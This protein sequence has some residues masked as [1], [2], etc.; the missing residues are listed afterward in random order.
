MFSR[1]ESGGTIP[2]YLMV[3][4]QRPDI[5]IIDEKTK[6]VTIFELTVPAEPRLDIAHT[7]KT[8]SYSHFSSDIKSHKVKVIPFEVGSNTGHI[9][10]ENKRRL[11]TLHSYCMKD[12]KL[13]RFKENIS[14]IAILSSYY[15]FNCRNQEV[16]STPDHILGPFKNQ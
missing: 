7:L 14:A 5:V 4:T 3:T 2:P 1:P 13:K 11:H 6:S 9:N 12:I 16:W 10:N 15:I 8:N